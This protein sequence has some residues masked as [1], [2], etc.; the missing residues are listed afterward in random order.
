MAE[1]TRVTIEDIT[2]PETLQFA[3]IRPDMNALNLR[4][5]GRPWAQAVLHGAV[6]KKVPNVYRFMDG[7]RK[8]HVVSWQVEQG[9][10]GVDRGNPTY[11]RFPLGIFEFP[12]GDF[13]ERMNVLKGDLGVTLSGE[14]RIISSGEKMVIPGKGR[15]VFS[16][17]RGEVLY[18]CDYGK[19]E[20]LR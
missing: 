16:V 4:F 10:N 17:E 15:V 1:F 11:G 13:S 8:I 3:S 18:V 5:K 14:T 7:D 12:L 20:F 6:D 19:P 9:Y 2:D